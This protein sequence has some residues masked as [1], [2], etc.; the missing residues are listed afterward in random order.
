MRRSAALA[1]ALRAERLGVAAVAAP[2][3]AAKTPLRSKKSSRRRSSSAVSVSRSPSV[4]RG[5]IG[6]AGVLRV[7]MMR[8][9]DARG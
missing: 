3:A 2:A 4:G 7:H 9:N 8:K 6:G 5:A 1:V